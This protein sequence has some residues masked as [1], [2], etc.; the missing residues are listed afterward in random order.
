MRTSDLLV[1][2]VIKLNINNVINTV[3][4]PCHD[5]SELSEKVRQVYI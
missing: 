4:L 1:I 2:R 5:K 3:I